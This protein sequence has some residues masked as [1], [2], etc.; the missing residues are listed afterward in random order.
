MKPGQIV[1]ALSAGLLLVGSANAIDLVEAWR[2]AQDHDLE[3]SAA[4]AAHE[5][6]ETRR[7][8][9][10]ALWRP[11]VSLTGTAGRMS[12]NTNTS[13]AQFSAPRFGLSN[14]VAFNTSVNDGTTRK[15]GRH[16]PTATDQ[17]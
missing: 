16:G 14:D 12:N 13:G 7:D 4:R 10:V 2:A 15:L 11:S 9:G 3:F 5:A 8:Q 17:R 1:A 6:G